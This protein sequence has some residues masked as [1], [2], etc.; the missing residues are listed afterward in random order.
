MDV[1]SLF[2]L[3]LQVE[4][5][6]V[7]QKYIARLCL[8]TSAAKTETSSSYLAHLSRFHLKMETETNLRNV[9]PYVNNSTVDNIQIYDSYINIPLSKTYGSYLNNSH[10]SVTSKKAP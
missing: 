6:K 5:T 1:M 10:F 8:R 2:C 4:P 9:V 3:R 7:G